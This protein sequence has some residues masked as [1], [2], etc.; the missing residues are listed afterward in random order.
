NTTLL[1]NPN[2]GAIR[3]LDTVCAGAYIQIVALQ[4]DTAQED[5]ITQRVRVITDSTSDLD[6]ETAISLGI[7]IVPIYVRWGD[8]TYVDGVSLTPAQFYRRLPVSN[9]HPLTAQPGPEVLASV[10]TRVP[11]CEGVVSIHISS[12]ISGTYNS[13]MLARSMVADSVPVEVIDSRLNSGGLTLV[14]MEAA[15]AARSGASMPEVAA[16]ARQAIEQVR[17]MALFDTM[18]YLARGGRISPAIAVAA[19]FLRVKPVLTFRDGIIIR[20][21]LVR[22]R[23]E[24]QA[25]LLRFLAGMSPVVEVAVSHSTYPEELDPFVE[26]VIAL[27]GDTPVHVFEM[28]A[29]LGVHGGP[30]MIV[31]AGRRRV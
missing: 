21:G 5:E 27:V 19:G 20:A 9:G 6:R 11:E 31:V 30:G 3:F 13:A 12:R 10:Y 2:C 14:V 29:A 24:G 28:G 1:G 4:A 22:S 26:R 16:A 8:E 25:R 7:E 23:A 15:R 18:K 17:M